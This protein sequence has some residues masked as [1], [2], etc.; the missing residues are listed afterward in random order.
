MKEVYI[1]TEVH[2]QEWVQFIT[3]S[4]KINHFEIKYK[5]SSK[6]LTYSKNHSNIKTALNKSSIPTKPDP[7]WNPRFTLL[8]TLAT[9]ID[10]MQNV[11]TSSTATTLL[12][13]AL[14]PTLPTV[15]HISKNIDTFF[16]AAL[17]QLS[18]LFC[19]NPITDIISSGIATCT[20]LY[21]SCQEPASWCEMRQRG[22]KFIVIFIIFY[23]S[24]EGY[25]AVKG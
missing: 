19:W 20:F 23:V 4:N 17:K 11:G 6:A 21:C 1:S 12:F 22:I 24:W 7:A 8:V 25:L 14:L 18:A 9:I 10:I 15:V 16:L 3:K 2:N 5:F 13:A